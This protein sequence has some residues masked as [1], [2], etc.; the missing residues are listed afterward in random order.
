MV[1]IFSLFNYLSNQYGYIVLIFFKLT[2]RQYAAGVKVKSAQI[3]K[4]L[5][6]WIHCN[7]LQNDVNDVNVRN[8]RQ[9][10]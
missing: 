7:L 1:S 5:L 3:V 9:F 4:G 2:T 8:D 10:D 6:P